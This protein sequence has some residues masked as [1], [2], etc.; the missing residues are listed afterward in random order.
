MKK[1]KI[2]CF[3]CKHFYVTWEKNFP[4]GCKAYQFKGKQM[5]SDYVFSASG[6]ECMTFE[7]KH[8]DK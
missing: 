6:Q 7:K 5:P 3:H 1:R 2:N 8:K 4:R